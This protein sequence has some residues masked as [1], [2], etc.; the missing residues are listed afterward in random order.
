MNP[1]TLCCGFAAY[2]NNLGGGVFPTS[3]EYS[4]VA[5][6]KVMTHAGT[7]TFDWSWVDS[8]LVATAQRGHHAILRLYVDYPS[9]CGGPNEDQYESAVPAD[10]TKG[11]EA[12]TFTAYSDHGGGLSPDYRNERLIAAFEAAIAAFGAR[13]DGDA[14]IACIQ[15]G[16]LG[17]WGEWHTYGDNE[18]KEALTPPRSTQIRVLTTYNTAFTQTRLMVSQDEM[19][20]WSDTQRQA[21]GER[22]KRRGST[23]GRW[24]SHAHSLPL[25]CRPLPSSFCVVRVGPPPATRRPPTRTSDGMTTVSQGAQQT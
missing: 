9:C 14:R 5:L 13:Y 2:Y 6:N 1:T 16:L 7:R 21:L 19:I 4:Y 15:L 17:F 24:G 10:L 20:Y 22:R 8:L 3:L 12:V 11:S 18:N 25:P 23:Q